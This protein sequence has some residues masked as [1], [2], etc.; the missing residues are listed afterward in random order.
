MGRGVFVSRAHPDAGFSL[1]EALVA[2]AVFATAAIAL[3]V[4]QTQ[5]IRAAQAQETR[6]L[7]ALVAQNLVVEAAAATTPTPL[8][9]RSGTVELA[10]RAW[11]WRTDVA[12]TLDA[13]VH[14]MRVMVFAA[15]ADTEVARLDAFVASGAG[16]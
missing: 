9:A 14:R 2:M 12:A 7:A 16:P 5:T 6:T 8:G 15:D 1:I 11:T 13:S 4:M 10:G 3:V